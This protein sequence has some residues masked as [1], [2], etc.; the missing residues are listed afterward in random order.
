MGTIGDIKEVAIVSVVRGTGY[1][2]TY[3]AGI[4]NY[5]KYLNQ[6]EFMW[7]TFMSNRECSI[8]RGWKRS[9]RALSIF[10]VDIL[11]MMQATGGVN[12]KTKS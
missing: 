5:L 12:A 10:V 7:A 9:G 3:A 2:I 11:L 6:V 8:N 1:I 4:D